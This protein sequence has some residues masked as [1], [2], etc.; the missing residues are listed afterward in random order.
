MN[1]ILDR[2]L[3]A[4]AGPGHRRWPGK[5]KLVAFLL[6]AFLLT[7]VLSAC[8]GDNASQSS[9]KGDQA[10]AFSLPDQYGNTYTFTPGDGKKHVLVFYMGYFCGGCRDQLG[11]L[12]KDIGSLEAEAEV[13]A[14]S[15]DS[16]DG[17]AKM[18]ALTGGR[19]RLLRDASMAVTLSYNMEMPG[20]PDRGYVVIDGSGRI[21]ERKIDPLVGENTG[22]I[23]A[24]L[25]DA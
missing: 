25:E 8:G 10:T 15:N 5:G 14:I 12:V 18:S 23:L 20:M 17:M 1:Q 11:K 22:D 19:I 24:V 2:P 3:T 21:V 7:V 6:V 4:G 13:V 16:L 9:G